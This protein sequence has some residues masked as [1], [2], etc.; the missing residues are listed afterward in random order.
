MV[1]LTPNL[2]ISFVVTKKEALEGYNL[3]KKWVQTPC[4][5]YLPYEGLS[6]QVL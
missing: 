1:V 4:D 3:N 6:M 5:I 2:K